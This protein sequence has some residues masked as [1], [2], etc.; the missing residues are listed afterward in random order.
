VKKG[1]SATSLLRCT[2]ATR[3]T[4]GVARIEI[5]FFE[6]TTSYSGLAGRGKIE[7]DVAARSAPP[8]SFGHDCADR[9]TLDATAAEVTTSASNITRTSKAA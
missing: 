9:V 8:D 5:N 3:P 4:S 6:M 2:A 1:G 7:D